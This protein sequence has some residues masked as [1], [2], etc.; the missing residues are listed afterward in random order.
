MTFSTALWCKNEGLYAATFLN[1][2][3]ESE[4]KIFGPPGEPYM[5][6][7]DEFLPFFGPKN[8][9]DSTMYTELDFCQCSRTLES[10]KNILFT[11][12]EPL[13]HEKNFRT[14]QGTTFGARCAKMSIFAINSEIYK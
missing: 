2:G 14:I 9:V 3:L 12:F 4:I 1:L 5:V 10:A 11:I 7:N 6:P 13:S 8:R